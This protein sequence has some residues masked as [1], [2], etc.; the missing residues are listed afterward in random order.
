MIFYGERSQE[1]R[2]IEDREDFIIDL[3]GS[4]LSKIWLARGTTLARVRLV[5]CTLSGAVLD[6]VEGL[7]QNRIRGAKAAQTEPPSLK[8]AFDCDTG[9]LLAWPPTAPW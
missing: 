8:D 9:Q 2:Q 1:A 5:N 6:G 4:D 7:T 3:Q